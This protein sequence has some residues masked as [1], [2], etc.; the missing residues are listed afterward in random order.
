MLT[1][2][3][4]RVTAKT[5]YSKQNLIGFASSQQPETA[6]KSSAYFYETYPHTFTH[7][8]ASKENY[9]QHPGTYPISRQQCA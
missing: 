2:S 7:M 6:R 5:R 3:D 9:A 1:A 4:G 8:E